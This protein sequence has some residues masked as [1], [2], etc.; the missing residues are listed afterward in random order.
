M[1]DKA[2]GFAVFDYCCI[3]ALKYVYVALSIVI[4]F[5]WDTLSQVT[6]LIDCDSFVLKIMVI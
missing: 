5:T 4:L 2:E 1:I 6:V 3:N